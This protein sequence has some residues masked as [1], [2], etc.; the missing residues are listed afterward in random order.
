MNLEGENGG[1]NEGR[2]RGVGGLNKALLILSKRWVGWGGG[3]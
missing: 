3:S 1:G 2:K